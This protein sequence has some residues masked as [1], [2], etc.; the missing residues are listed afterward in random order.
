MSVLPLRLRGRE[1]IVHL[2]FDIGVIG[3]G[4]DGVLEILGGVLLFVLSPNR[5][6]AIVRALTQ[7]ELSQDPN[8]AVAH[9][10]LES[11]QHLTGDTKL[12]GAIFLLGHGAV[13]VVLVAGLLR[14]QAWA[15]PI[16]M[17]AFFAFVVY[18][19]YRYTHTHSNWLIVLSVLDLFVIGL[20]WL[21]YQRLKRWHALRG[22]GAPL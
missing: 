3:K 19:L 2:L 21:E 12:F 9:F 22:H 4:I 15:Y 10:I 8:D 7:H 17:L 11:A 1:R 16:G 18:E 13:K 5:I 14:K 20:T 6:D